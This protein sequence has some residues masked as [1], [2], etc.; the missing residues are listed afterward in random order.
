MAGNRDEIRGC[1]IQC[2]HEV[3]G[4][5][6][7]TA[8][9]DQ[10]EPIRGLGLDSE[11]GVNFACRL[12]NRL[13]YDIPDGINPL[14]DDEGHRPRRVGEITDLVCKLLAT[15]KEENDG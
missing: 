7:G 1:V 3:L 12:S 4:D 11:D 9:D 5:K 15:R 2:L 14:L 13:N 8:I 6:N 10:T